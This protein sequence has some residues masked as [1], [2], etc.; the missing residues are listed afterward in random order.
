[1]TPPEPTTTEMG[2]RGRL[3]RRLLAWFLLFSLFPLLV[4]NAIGY[5]RSQG[6]ITQLVERYL[7]AIA[8]VQ[9][10]HVRDRTDRALLLLQAVAAG[11]EFLAA[12][13]LR[14]QGLPTGVMGKAASRPEMERLL[15]RKLDELKLFDA[16]YLFTPDGAIAASVGIRENLSTDLPAHEAAA[17]LSAMLLSTPR[18]VRPMFRLVVPVNG[19]ERVP[20]AFLAATLSLDG[21]RDMLQLPDRVAGHVESF[22]V[23][24]GGRPLFV[25]HPHD[26]VDYAVPLV[27]PLLALPDGVHEQYFAGNGAPVLGTIV[28]LPDYEWRLIV[29]VPADE[30]F[31]ALRRLG[32]LS[33]LLELLLVA[34]LIGTAVVVSRSVVAP[35]S[36]LVHA[37]RR[38]AQGDRSVRVQD[39]TGDEIGELGHAFNEMT[40]ALAKTTN[41]VRELHQREIE[42]ASQLATVGELASGIAHEI[43]NPVVGVANGL[44]IVRRR[45]GTD[46]TLLPIIDEME[47]QIRRVQGAIQELLTFARPAIPALAP[48][49]ANDLAERAIRLVQPTADKGGVRIEAR[50]DPSHASVLA[51]AEM[52]HQALINLLMNAIEATPHGGRVDVYTRT[53]GDWIEID[54]TDTGRGI[55]PEHLESVFKPFFTTRHTGTGLG[56]SIT[57]EI[58]QRHGGTVAL[59]SRLGEGTTVTMRLP[60]HASG[61]AAASEEAAE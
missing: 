24:A 58:I 39:D 60:A 41:D 61:A 31:G 56:L 8:Q 34:V 38:V 47:R 4:T 7:S 10:Q 11:N 9:A 59:R 29:E 54:I 15:R 1:M 32:S 26:T 19:S 14:S 17:S 37:S 12:G 18:G 52:I 20:V 2:R 21:F 13:A 44:D 49:S 55:S 57:R 46:A 27:T 16:L 25:S 51:D 22:I 53:S 30:A 33:L 45:A 5:R 28:A 43:K 3:S 36:R 48:V 35:L 23:D 40:S 50:L 6:I 42:R